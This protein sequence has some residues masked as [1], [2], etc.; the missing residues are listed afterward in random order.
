MSTTTKKAAT[1]KTGKVSF[2]NMESLPEEGAGA[3]TAPAEELPFT[4]EESTAIEP[5]TALAPAGANMSDCGL[6]G[7]WDMDDMKYPTL[8]VLSSLSLLVKDEGYPDGSIN[9][10]GELTVALADEPVRICVLRAEKVWQ[11][12]LDNSDEIPQVFASL[13][14]A[15]A[16][17][18]SREFTAENRVR[19]CCRATLLVEKPEDLEDPAGL[20]SFEFNGK[21]YTVA[22]VVWSKTAYKTTGEKIFSYVMFQKQHIRSTWWTLKS[23]EKSYKN[24]KW[25]SP[26]L[27]RGAPLSEKEF[28]FAS[29]VNAL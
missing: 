19:P 7:D 24:K 5:S 23:D 9:L 15:Q 6:E 25:N 1:K 12:H 20:F 10:N 2:A 27:S 16:A 14:E 22:G 26:V 18:F 4:E 29:E 17:G 28:E 13:K 3:T 11:E 21:L 8:R